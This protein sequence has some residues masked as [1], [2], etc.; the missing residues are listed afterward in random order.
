VEKK[1]RGKIRADKKQIII[2]GFEMKI[3]IFS[4]TFFYLLGYRN[5]AF[6]QSNI[7]DSEV[8]LFC[9]DSGKQ[10][11]DLLIYLGTNNIKNYNVGNA[12]VFSMF[13]LKDIKKYFSTGRTYEGLKQR[14]DSS[15]FE[16]DTT[17]PI[18]KEYKRFPEYVY[19]KSAVQINLLFAYETQSVI[20]SF[21]KGE[22][23]QSRITRIDRKTGDVSDYA[24]PYKLNCQPIS[25][26]DFRSR[27]ENYKNMSMTLYNEHADKRLF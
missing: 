20:Y 1:F 6:S 19:T 25:E 26:P 3:I 21:G 12:W 2:L 8:F 14:I 27:Y 15:N 9:V 23:I 10:K 7:L 18:N 24:T 11:K 22:S 17:S 16:E 4:L 5:I 13:D